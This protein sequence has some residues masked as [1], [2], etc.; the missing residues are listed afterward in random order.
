MIPSWQDPDDHG[1]PRENGRE[2]NDGI[3][4]EGHEAPGTWQ[5]LPVD[6]VADGFLVD[7]VDDALVELVALR[8]SA[9]A[10]IRGRRILVTVQ[11]SCGDPSG[12]CR[13][14]G[15]QSGRRPPGL[16]DSRCVRR[17]QHAR[18]GSLTCRARSRDRHGAVP[19]REVRDAC[20]TAA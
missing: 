8:L 1:V 7:E 6:P 17:V 4:G 20:A 3:P 13:V 18:G 9:E 15:G 11:N 14:G 5:I 19:I 10:E 12:Q 16:G 2:A